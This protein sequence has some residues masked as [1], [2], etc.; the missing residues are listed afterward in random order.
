[1][2]TV[3]DHSGFSVRLRKV[4]P[5]DA[6]ILSHWLRT[7]S[8]TLPT[9]AHTSFQIS[10]TW[11][12][13]FLSDRSDQIYLIVLKESHRPI[14]LSVI[15]RVDRQSRTAFGGL[16]IFEQA[17]RK[18]GRGFEAKRLQLRYAFGDLNLGIV[19]SRVKSS[20]ESIIRGLKKFGYQTQFQP[21]RE[22]LAAEHTILSLERGMWAKLPEDLR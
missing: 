5:A 16:A 3:Q 22:A 17:E 14:G 4:L 18:L 15:Y 6:D 11:R 2:I 1:M 21:T 13:I 10:S 12:N 7:S 19:Y 20:N 8:E 9:L